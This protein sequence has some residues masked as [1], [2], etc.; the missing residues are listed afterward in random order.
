MQD[1]KPGVTLERKF[2]PLS[3]VMSD[4]PTTGRTTSPKICTAS[5]MEPTSSLCP[6]AGDGGTA[7]VT[8]L[9]N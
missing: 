8:G 1:P 2:Q 6:V 7:S 3:R 4:S 5:S 9:P